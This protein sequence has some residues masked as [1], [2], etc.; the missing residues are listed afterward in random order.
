MIG[1]TGRPG[2]SAAARRSRST[3]AFAAADS[4][5]GAAPACGSR[6]S[7]SQA[8]VAG[9]PAQQPADSRARPRGNSAA[10]CRAPAAAAS[11]RRRAGDRRG[12]RP[13]TPQARCP[14]SRASADSRSMPYRHQSRPPSSRTRITLAWRAD[15]IDPQ[16]DR[17]RV[18]QVAQMREPHARQR[19]RAPR[20]RRRQGRRDRCRRTTAPRCRRAAGRDRPVRRSR[21]GWSRW[22]RGGASL[23]P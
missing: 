20:P 17:H 12:L 22:S 21:R 18:A 4:R 1:T 23:S 11:R 8:G 6:A 14:R 7:S 5:R 19:R 15:A 2:S 16:I 13:A 10:A 3:G 9:E